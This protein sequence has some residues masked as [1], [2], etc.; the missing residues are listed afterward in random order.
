MT[1]QGTSP[2]W[3]ARAGVH[4]EVL[5]ELVGKVAGMALDEFAEK[6][7]FEPLGMRDTHFRPL[8]TSRFFGER[9]G[10]TDAS[11]TPLFLGGLNLTW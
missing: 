9:M 5:G 1:N 7:V 3:R 2:G 6:N 10:L 11:Q 4:L 8:A